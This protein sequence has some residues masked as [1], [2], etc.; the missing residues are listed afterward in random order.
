M[1]WIGYNDAPWPTPY[2]ADGDGCTASEPRL[3][4]ATVL[5]LAPKIVDWFLAD[6]KLFGRSYGDIV[7]VY[8]D[9]GYAYEPDLSPQY[10]AL[11]RRQEPDTMRNDFS[12]AN[13]HDV[14]NLHRAVWLLILHALARLLNY[15]L[16]GDWG[17][18]PGGATSQG[19]YDDPPPKHDLTEGFHTIPNAYGSYAISTQDIPAPDLGIGE[20]P[21]PP[22][23]TPPI[24]VQNPLTWDQIKDYA[25]RLARNLAYRRN[26]DDYGQHPYHRIVKRFYLDRADHTAE[27]AV[28]IGNVVYPQNRD[29][30]NDPNNPTNLT[31][32]AD[33]AA[34][35]GPEDVANIHRGAWLFLAHRFSFVVGKNPFGDYGY[36]DPQVGAPRVDLPGAEGSDRVF[37]VPNGVNVNFKLNLDDIDPDDDP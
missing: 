13:E 17:D 20:A 25:R 34:R 3:R 16:H 35:I 30:P 21:Y 31:L 19:R 5:T 27:Y 32:A 4:R 11:L 22:Q 26:L 29:D 9:A 36:V 15:N 24:V 10:L 37:E 6:E 18:P 33:L 8:K 23:V 1:A 2:R 7:R 14:A 12:I 28:A